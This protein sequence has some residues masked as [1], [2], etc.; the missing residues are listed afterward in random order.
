MCP[1][2][3]S[4]SFRASTSSA[5]TIYHDYEPAAEEPGLVHWRYGSQDSTDSGDRSDSG[6]SKSSSSASEE[7]VFVDNLS[8][9]LQ[10]LGSTMLNNYADPNP[11]KN[12][13]AS[14]VTAIYVVGQDQEERM[15]QLANVG[16]SDVGLRTPGSPQ[17]VYADHASISP[18]RTKYITRVAD[19]SL[20]VITATE[21]EEKLDQQNIRPLYY[22]Q[23]ATGS[24]GGRS[25]TEFDPPHLRP[26]KTAVSTIANFSPASAAASSAPRNDHTHS[27]LGDNRRRTL[28]PFA[29][30]PRSAR[31]RRPNMSSI[32][33]NDD[34]NP[35]T[36]NEPSVS[37]SP[38][39]PHPDPQK[40]YPL[41]LLHC[42][43]RALPAPWPSNVQVPESMRSDFALLKRKLEGTVG[44]RGI[45]L[46]HPKASYNQLIEG[47]LVTTGLVE[48]SVS[49][50][51]TRAMSDFI[52]SLHTGDC[53]TNLL[54]CNATLGTEKVRSNP[55]GT[56]A[57]RCG[58]SLAKSHV[59]HESSHYREEEV[60]S[61]HKRWD[62]RVY[63]LSGLMGA[64]AWRAA[65]RDMERVDVEVGVWA[66]ESQKNEWELQAV[67]Q[68]AWS[69]MEFR[70]SGVSRVHDVTAH[71]HEL[72][73][74]P[75]C[76]HDPV[77][78]QSSCDEPAMGVEI[79]SRQ[80]CSARVMAS[81]KRTSKSV[82]PWSGKRPAQQRLPLTTL[83]GNYFRRLVSRS[84]SLKWLLRAV[85][86]VVLFRL[87]AILGH[88][89]FETSTSTELG[90]T[91]I[92]GIAVAGLDAAASLVNGSDVDNGTDSSALHRDDLLD[93]SEETMS[94]D[95]NDLS[96]QHIQR[97]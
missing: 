92:G 38:T 10:L 72:H 95:A 49:T 94:E 34:H 24:D 2:R 15:A 55:I 47:I 1:L 37:P 88:G 77:P 21:E 79:D 81:A 43:V 19:K 28:S 32:S 13:E 83:L 53:A 30:S 31:H 65:W 68:A 80:E 7:V 57:A 48:V 52:P 82:C 76:L 90:Y 67:E 71:G 73:S 93:G 45:L 29:S 61:Q 14:T 62:V 75:D 58:A 3:R 36:Q 54:D 9:G 17:P 78:E 69:P 60:L 63:A 85:V 50:Y 97:T 51:A 40:E 42:K 5:I 20:N 4:T 89:P 12:R 39:H 46:E 16:Q 27:S 96:L 70:Q 56:R 35:S 64:G 66:E 59:Q 26:F 86:L 8:S 11:E 41:I 44:A 23:R 22:S 74:P 25:D 33:A 91:A 18:V 87:G 84:A 6:S